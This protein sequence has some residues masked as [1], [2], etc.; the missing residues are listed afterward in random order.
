M[1]DLLG[2]PF[3]DPDQARSLRLSLAGR[4]ALA[5]TKFPGATELVEPVSQLQTTL[6]VFLKAKAELEMGTIESVSL[7]RPGSAR[8]V[9]Y[10]R[11]KLALL[12]RAIAQIRSGLKFDGRPLA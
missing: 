9:V 3:T 7:R 6:E 11:E 8:A 2:L 4:A 1:S 5:E 10:D 12:D